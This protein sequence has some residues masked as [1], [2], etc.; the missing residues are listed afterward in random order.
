[1]RG[2]A[3]GKEWFKDD[4]TSGNKLYIEIN[5]DKLYFT[6]SEMENVYN[7]I[8]SIQPKLLEYIYMKVENKYILW[9]KFKGQFNAESKAKLRKKMYEWISEPGE[10][11]VNSIDTIE[12]PTDDMKVFKG[13]SYKEKQHDISNVKVVNMKKKT[14]LRQD[15]IDFMHQ[16][17]IMLIEHDDIFVDENYK[18]LSYKNIDNKITEFGLYTKYKPTQINKFLKSLEYKPGLGSF[19]VRTNIPEYRPRRQYLEFSDCIYDTFTSKQYKK[20]TKFYDDDKIEVHPCYKFDKSFMSYSRC[21]PYEYF[22]QVAKLMEPEM[23]EWYF[24]QF[25]SELTPGD[26]VSILSYPYKIE[27]IGIFKPFVNMYNNV[28]YN[29]NGTNMSSFDLAN[30]TRHDIL[31]TEGLN[32]LVHFNK[33]K[34]FTPENIM[35]M[36]EGKETIVRKKYKE[37]EVSKEKIVISI[38]NNSFIYIPDWLSKN[39]LPIELPKNTVKLDPNEFIDENVH[40]I[41]GFIIA[42]MMTNRD[43]IKE[44]IKQM[45]YDNKWNVEI[46]VHGEPWPNYESHEYIEKPVNKTFN[47]EYRDKY[48]DLNYPKKILL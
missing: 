10:I 26:N 17:K 35:P 42:N 46:K 15:F 8:S 11:K 30:C 45:R 41:G 14:S 1:M 33:N 23:F 7:L 19:G 9:V 2:K 40:H 28:L 39:I 4:F 5:S 13:L 25:T 24:D 6:D 29:V 47:R 48:S 3:I 44:Y 27:D 20:Q 43:E 37:P 36:I 32:P 12:L 34:L 31:Y 16:Y 38:T 21:I 18:Q 22:N